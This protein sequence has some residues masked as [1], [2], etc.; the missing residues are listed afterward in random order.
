MYEDHHG[1]PCARL[2]RHESI[3]SDTENSS[4][5]EWPFLLISSLLFQQPAIYYQE[6]RKVYVDDMLT[7]VSWHRLVE[8]MKRDWE[9]AIIPVGYQRFHCS[10][11][12]TDLLGNRVAFHERRTARHTKHRQLVYHYR[13]KPRSN[14][15][16]HLRISQPVTTTCC[17]SAAT[18]VPNIPVGQ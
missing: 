7:S 13:P 11:V 5:S 16:L 14:S 3:F 6:L 9:N 17:P 2:S 15:Q 4:K 8:K 10:G 12:L 18:S 1:E